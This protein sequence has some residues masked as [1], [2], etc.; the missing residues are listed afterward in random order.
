MERR[1]TRLFCSTHL[2]AGLEVA[3]TVFFFN[4]L[5]KMILIYLSLFFNSYPRYERIFFFLIV[6]SR[7]Q[8]PFNDKRCTIRFLCIILI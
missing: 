5:D 7:C 8:T 1:K 2:L 3:D 6:L 4:T